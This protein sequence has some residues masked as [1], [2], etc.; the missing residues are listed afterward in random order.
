MMRAMFDGPG[1]W[2]DTIGALA[3]EAEKSWSGPK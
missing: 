3:A 1:A 2:I